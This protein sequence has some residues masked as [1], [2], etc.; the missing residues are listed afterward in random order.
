MI[1]AITRNVLFG[2][3]VALFPAVHAQTASL[4]QPFPPPEKLLPGE[5]TAPAQQAPDGF[6]LPVRFTP[7]VDRVYWD[8]PLPRRIPSDAT[9]LCL[10]LSCPDTVPIRGLTVHLQSGDGWYNAAPGFT[11]GAHRV[12]TLPRGLF[13][14]ENSPGPW[15]KSRRL[16][17]SAWRQNDGDTRIILHDITTRADPVAV[18]R[19]TGLTAPGETAFAAS[20]ADRC[21]RLLT[22]ANIPFT[23]IDDSFD[24]L[25][26]FKLLLLPY[27]P[28]LPDK[29]LNRLDRFV[30][31]NGKLIVFYNASEPL[32]ALLGVRPGSWQGTAAGEEWTA[33]VCDDT[34]LA[35]APLRV[36]HVTNSILPPFATSSYHARAI[37]T[38]A[39]DTG[40]MTDQP[41]G[42]LTD[43]GAWFAHVPT[44]AYPSAVSLVRAL[45]FA[46]VPEAQTPVAA[47]GVRATAGS[48]PKAPPAEIRAAWCN[49]A[50]HPRGW[51]GLLQNLSTNGISTLFVRWPLL[52][53][54]NRADPLAAL[55]AAS[56]K[57]GVAVHAWFACLTLD[58]AAPDQRAK[59]EREGR[60]MRDAAGNA[61]PWLCPS[62]PENRTFL[63][64]G[65][66]DLARR[67]VQGIHLDYLRYPD[68]GCY[69]PA[70]RRAFEAV[71][72]APVAAW[73]ADVLAGGRH[74]A[75]FQK[76]R[77]DTITAFA[78]EAR[79]AIRA[80]A[81]SVTV[82][83]AVFPT[84][85]AAASRGQNWP[86]WLHE[87][88]LDFACPMIYTE[89]A[90][91][92]AAALDA[93]LA[94]APAS[95]LV[96]GI[97][98]GA[99]ES[100]LDD[101]TTAL[102][103]SHVRNRRLA[104]FAFFAVDDELMTSILPALSLK[105]GHRH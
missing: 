73:P 87:G 27:A 98:T 24:D 18:I 88:L 43:R 101:V 7:A 14:A 67:G 102:Q 49:A 46:L 52:D 100:Q 76:F 78:R 44:L 61:L 92:F 80:A 89:S 54:Q 40:R 38:W 12:I 21:G 31:H 81:P 19:A 36:P 32:G 30:K 74:A 97:G 62:L 93:C 48:L 11:A 4:L 23:V 3:S 39:D 83:A 16:R 42:V 105:Q 56:R 90:A 63:I 53:A 1:K 20:L 77:C 85:D 51:N 37:A 104:G 60:L 13:Q 33:L 10:D 68:A 35:G 5:Q 86:A 58:G 66:R 99:D 71:L 34:R 65:L 84:P 59:F 15:Q 2:L 6:L 45:A 75:A 91:D 82:S 72:G 55:Q 22:K 8:L 29:Q 64:G 47:S 94:A 57:Q 26:G 79:A 25:D 41:A 69:A 28:K 9:T 95:L 17:L 50:R 103:I 70:T 96:P